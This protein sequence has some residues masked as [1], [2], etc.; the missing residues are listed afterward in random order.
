MVGVGLCGKVPECWTS[1]CVASDR[2]GV[3]LSGL[4]CVRVPRN[5]KALQFSI[6]YVRGLFGV[7]FISLPFVALP[8]RVALRYLPR[9]P[10]LPSPR[11][12]LLY[13]GLFFC[14]SLLILSRDATYTIVLNSTLGWLR[15]YF[16]AA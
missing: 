12:A 6:F 5:G 8:L 13:L 14:S 16:S 1:G 3:G 7:T 15:A 9:H 10:L 11:G 2:R 4:Q